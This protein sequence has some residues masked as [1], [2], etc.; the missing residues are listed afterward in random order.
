MKKAIPN[1]LK[2]LYGPHNL[3]PATEFDNLIELTGKVKK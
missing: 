1:L 2:V 3:R